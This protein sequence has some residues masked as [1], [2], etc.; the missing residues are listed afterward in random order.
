MPGRG[1]KDTGLEKRV[2][3]IKDTLNSEIKNQS[4]K[5]T[6]K[7]LNTLDGIKSR[8]RKQKNELVTRRTE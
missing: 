2:G 6:I 1:L 5:N 4:E 3:N 8:L 7:I